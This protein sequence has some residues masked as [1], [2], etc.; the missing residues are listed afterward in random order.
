MKSR[1]QC[2]VEELMIEVEKANANAASMEKKQKMFDKLI[3]EWKQKCEDLTLELEGAQKESRQLSTEVYKIR[4]Q[5]QESVEL[6]EGVRRENQNLAEEI[7]DLME[8]L[9]NGGK[10]VHEL[11]KLVK[12][13]E[14]EKEEVQVGLEDA[15]KALEQ[16]EARYF[17]TNNFI[18]MNI[19]KFYFRFN[20]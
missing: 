5:Y 3:Q 7:K 20:H 11:E 6:G 4:A 1:L 18:K 17:K 14:M 9:A 16:A 10:N 8:Q 15:E 13:V 2:D 12:R 19:C